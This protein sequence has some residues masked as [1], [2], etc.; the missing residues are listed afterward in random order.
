MAQ[1]EGSSHRTAGPGC[2]LCVRP[3]GCR[4]EVPTASSSGS[5]TLLERLPELR[6]TF[7]SLH[8]QFIVKG[9]DSGAG[10]WKRCAG[11]G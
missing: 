11:R 8:S 2:H 5:I 10:A 9:P 6:E 1:G 4:A 7:H 3:A